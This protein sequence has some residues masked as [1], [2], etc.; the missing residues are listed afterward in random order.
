MAGVFARWVQSL[1]CVQPTAQAIYESESPACTRAGR[2]EYN[3]VVDWRQRICG[4]TDM[5]GEHDE[6]Q[7]DPIHAYSPDDLK[8]ARGS[9]WATVEKAD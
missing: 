5:G 2:S 6:L 4:G 8:G 7:R 1:Y 9:I 3:R